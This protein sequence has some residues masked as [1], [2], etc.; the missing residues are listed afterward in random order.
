MAINYELDDAAAWIILPPGDRAILRFAYRGSEVPAGYSM[1]SFS[2]VL[3]A[4]LGFPFPWGDFPDSTKASHLWRKHWIGMGG[5]FHHTWFIT[6]D[7][8][9][10]GASNVPQTLPGSLR[11]SMYLDG[12]NEDNLCA[13]RDNEGL[14]L[15]KATT[16]REQALY[17]EVQIHAMEHVEA[18]GGRILVSPIQSDNTV[19]AAFTGRCLVCPNIEKISVRQLQASVPKFEFHLYP[20]WR[21]WL[22]GL[23]SNSEIDS[24]E[25]VHVK[26]ETRAIPSA[27]PA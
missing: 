3:I 20:E 24:D 17:R 14:A 15:L 2:E 12:G 23:L 5:L 25:S 4:N 6:K 19:H 13:P 10:G 26:N 11:F 9:L 16:R 22:E 21:N 18:D 27:L 1:A 7:G 8:R